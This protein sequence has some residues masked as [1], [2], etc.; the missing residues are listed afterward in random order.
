MAF[1]NIRITLGLF[2]VRVLYLLG[3]FGQDRVVT[4]TRKAVKN[5]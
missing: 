1:G 3:A 2:V 5:I 4:S